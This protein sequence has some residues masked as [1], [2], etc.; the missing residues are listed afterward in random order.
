[1]QFKTSFLAAFAALAAVTQASY[2][3]A[4]DTEDGHYRVQLDANGNALGEPLKISDVSGKSKRSASF[5]LEARQ[6]PSPSVNC[7]GYGI[8]VSDFAVTTSGL[9]SWCDSGNELSPNSLEYWVYQTSLAYICN[10]ASGDNP[11]SSYEYSSANQLEDT[12]CGASNAGW[13]YISDWAKSYGRG[14]AG[15]SVCW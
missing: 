5:S 6:F 2:H 12:N 15:I 14:N 7:N 9:N 3:V 13:V 10:Y 4:A 11:C 8:S 1:M